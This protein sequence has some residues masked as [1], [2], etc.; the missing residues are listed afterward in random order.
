MAMGELTLRLPRKVG[1]RITMDRFLSS[2]EAAGLVRQGKSFQSPN[3]ASSPRHLD[4]DL[5]TAMG[6]VQVEWVD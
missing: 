5:T 1:L 2:F 6:G 3:Y 4:L